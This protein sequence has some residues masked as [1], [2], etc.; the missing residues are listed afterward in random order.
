MRVQRVIRLVLSAYVWGFIAY[1]LLPV[2]IIPYTNY[3]P[4]E[5][6]PQPIIYRYSFAYDV[7]T[8]FSNHAG[9]IKNLLK[10]MD[11]RGFDIAFGDFPE[12]IEDRLFPTPRNK[13]CMVIRASEVPLV[14]ELLHTLFE[15]FPKIL[16][17]KTP[18]DVL[19][20]RLYDKP[21][22]C[23]LVAHDDRILLSTFFGVDVPSYD[24]ILGNRRNVYQSKDILLRESYVEDFLKGALVIFGRAKVKVF[25]YSD[26][27][28]Y[29]PGGKTPYS[30]RY[31]VDTNLKN[32]IILLFHN[33]RLKGIYEQNR[34]NMPV[35]DS[36]R[37][38]AHIL[39][40]KFKLY[41]FY[42][43]LRSVALAS[44]IELM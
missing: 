31:V 26:R 28:F 13:G 1:Q 9:S 40:Y 10:A 30:F 34:L 15:R 8:A 23:Y 39:S 17:G 6:Y 21:S 19:M 7:K 18:E 5:F 41:I 12:N 38:T 43:G 36:G 3:A 33:G 29:L 44:P 37:Y 32:P 4:Q 25:A 22:D 20:R 2:H 16:V 42:F 35:S 27:S 11:R 14:E 24:Y